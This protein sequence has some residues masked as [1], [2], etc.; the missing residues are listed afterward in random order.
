MT[1]VIA[2]LVAAIAI[3]V[4]MYNVLNLGNFGVFA[5]IPLGLTPFLFM[6]ALL[7]ARVPRNAVGWLLSGSGILFA[8]T[9]VGGEYATVALVNDP[10]RLPG[11]EVGAALSQ[12][13]YPGAISLIVLLLLYFPSGRGLGGRWTWVERALIAFSVFITFVDLFRDVPV[14]LGP[15]TSDGKQAEIPNALAL[16]G[17]FGQLVTAVA[18]V[19]DKASTPLV[20]LAPLSLFVRFR[21]SSTTE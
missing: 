15:M 1:R 13:C 11:G 4:V 7:I 18:Q 8:L 21:R 5:L 3:V 16:P 2:G 10:G 17:A 12:G 20:L 14:Q 6:G 9:F 19:V